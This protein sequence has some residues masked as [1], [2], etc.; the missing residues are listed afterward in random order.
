MIPDI[1]SINLKITIP[2]ILLSDER[3]DSPAKDLSSAT[4]GSQEEEFVD[5][6]DELPV[7]HFQPAAP[8][9]MLCLLLDILQQSHFHVF[10]FNWPLRW[11][12]FLVGLYQFI[13]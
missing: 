9:S 12:V 1:L 11:L 13:S 7:D 3:L 4:N 5:A 2:C 8:D 10:F 6:V